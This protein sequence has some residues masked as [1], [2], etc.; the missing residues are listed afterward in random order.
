MTDAL[1]FMTYLKELFGY[2]LYALI[3]F[4]LF[5]EEVVI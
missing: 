4:E 2:F 5:Y 3:V 1:D